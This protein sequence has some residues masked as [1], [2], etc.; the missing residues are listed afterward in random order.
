MLYNRP[1]TVDANLIRAGFLFWGLCKA[2]WGSVQG[3]LGMGGLCKAPW[4]WGLCKAPWGWCSAGGG[5]ATP[6]LPARWSKCGWFLRARKSPTGI[7][8]LGWA[9]MRPHDPSPLPQLPLRAPCAQPVPAVSFCAKPHPQVGFSSVTFS[10]S[11]SLPF[12]PS[13]TPSVFISVVV[14]PGTCPP[15]AGR[16]AAGP[17]P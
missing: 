5:K 8:G 16:R 15:T 14:L 6:V 12:L 13:S 2:P 11:L 1:Q 3:P 17:L 10:V 4:G 9:R 7:T